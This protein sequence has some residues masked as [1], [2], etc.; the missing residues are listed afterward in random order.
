MNKYM[1]I[2]FYSVLHDSFFKHLTFSGHVFGG[3]TAGAGV[4][5]ATACAKA[6]L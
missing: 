1:F 5:F 3:G 2:L 4:G 6:L